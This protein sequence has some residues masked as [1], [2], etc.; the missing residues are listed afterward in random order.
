LTLADEVLTPDSS[1]FWPASTYK[2]GGTQP[3]LDKQFVRDYVLGLG[4]DKTPPAPHLPEEIV[5]G[6]RSRYFEI[7]KRLTARDIVL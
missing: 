4:W 2:P 6:L 3:S 7:F 5:M 1:R